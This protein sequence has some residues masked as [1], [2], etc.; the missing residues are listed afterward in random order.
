M[1]PYRHITPTTE[2]GVLILSVELDEV[3]D[4][5]RAEELKYELSHAVRGAKTNQVVLDLHK[6][7]FMTSLACVAFI[8]V[9]HAVRERQG[10]LILCN[11]SEFIHKVLSAKRLLSP[12]QA[13][14]HVAFEQ[15]PTLKA[16]I[17][18][19]NSPPPGSVADSEG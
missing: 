9:K 18:M 1:N 8:G 5:I 3:K 10:R 13:N 7:E 11:M 6:M 15:A 16:A 2:Q 19:L 4:Y 12:S 17:A 14:G